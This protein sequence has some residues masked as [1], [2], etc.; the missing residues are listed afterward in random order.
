MLAGCFPRPSDALV[1][2]LASDCEAGRVCE[3]GFCV[4][5]PDA[6]ISTQEEVPVDAPV[7]T[8][9]STPDAPP[10]PCTGGDANATDVDGNCF[11]AF[12]TAATRKTRSAAALACEAED[13]TLAI[14][15]SADSN[16]TAQSL[17]TGLDAWLG[18]TDAVTENTFLWPDET[19]LVFENF[20]AGE[21]NNT[22]N[23]DCLVIEGAKGG[24]WDDRACGTVLSYICGF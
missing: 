3:S 8:P 14:I 6:S 17:I 11:V 20:R 24:S 22:N 21:P 23:E 16:A 18:A 4:V 1:C 7:L 2:T 13:M 12:R 5:G 9:D 15:N 19:P 10:R